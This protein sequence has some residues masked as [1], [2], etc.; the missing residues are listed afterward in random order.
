MEEEDT[1]GLLDSVPINL[2]FSVKEDFMAEIFN[3]YNIEQKK[4]IQDTHTPDLM[5]VKLKKVDG[6]IYFRDEE[7][8]VTCRTKE[9]FDTFTAG[10]EVKI[11]LY[12]D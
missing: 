6:L 5:E 7:A 11:V 10:K 9:E 3:I 12:T 1:E 2:F 4:L 8:F